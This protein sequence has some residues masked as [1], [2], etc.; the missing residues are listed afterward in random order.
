MNNHL[1]KLEEK[2]TRELMEV[3]IK[4]NYRMKEL[5]TTLQ[6]KN[7]AQ[8]RIVSIPVTNQGSIIVCYTPHF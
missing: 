3:E 5:L 8:Q 6:R 4:R 7:Q 2:L 1:D